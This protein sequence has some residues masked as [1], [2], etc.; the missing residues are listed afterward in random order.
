MMVYY[1]GRGIYKEMNVKNT[2][3]KNKK[4]KEIIVIGLKS[5]I[6]HFNINSV[7]LLNFPPKKCSKDFILE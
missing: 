3:K 2:E 6:T 4:N 7:I 5:C 1:R